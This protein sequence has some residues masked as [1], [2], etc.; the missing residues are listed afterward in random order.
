MNSNFSLYTLVSPKVHSS[1]SH[2]CSKCSSVTLFTHNPRE[3]YGKG[4]FTSLKMC[5][6]L[7]GNVVYKGKKQLFLIKSYYMSGGSE[8]H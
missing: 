4:R 1:L 8:C 6:T 7:F 3:F 2:L 5:S